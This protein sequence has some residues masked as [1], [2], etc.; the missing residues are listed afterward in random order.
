MKYPIKERKTTA[1]VRI[2]SWRSAKRSAAEAVGIDADYISGFVD[3]TDFLIMIE[4]DDD[5]IGA[6]AF[7]TKANE[8]RELSFDRFMQVA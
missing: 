3:R 5:L 7:D 1:L 6:V 2:A 8:W 4:E